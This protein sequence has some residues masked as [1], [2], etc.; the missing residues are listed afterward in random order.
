MSRKRAHAADDTDVGDDD[1]QAPPKKLARVAGK[2][3]VPEQEQQ[4]DLVVVDDDDDDD[5]KDDQDCES[6]ESSSSDSGDDEVEEEADETSSGKVDDEPISAAE[7][8]AMKQDAEADAA[9]GKKRG[10]GAWRKCRV[11]QAPPSSKDD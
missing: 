7:L 10:R 6:E 9:A 1:V 11:D 8:K 5:D 2:A 4:H 3:P